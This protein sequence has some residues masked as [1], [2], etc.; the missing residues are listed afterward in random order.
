MTEEQSTWAPPR[1]RVPVPLYTNSFSPF[2]WWKLLG[3]REE[4]TGRLP[5]HLPWKTNLL[6]QDH[7]EKVQLCGM[8][9]QSPARK[10]PASPRYPQ[11]QHWHV[12]PWIWDSDCFKKNNPTVTAGLDYA[13]APESSSNFCSFLSII[14]LFQWDW[15]CGKSNQRGGKLTATCPMYLT[16][17][18]SQT[19]L[20]KGKEY[21]LETKPLCSS[22]FV[23]VKSVQ[24]FHITSQKHS[25]FPKV[26]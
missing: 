5:E 8:Q 22:N 7:A 9:H 25:A 19:A 24:L 21:T 14:L 3:T 11:T 26:F 6:L 13:L 16:W 12:A 4:F 1:A 10:S 2:R 20:S 18:V 23:P 17:S 15:L